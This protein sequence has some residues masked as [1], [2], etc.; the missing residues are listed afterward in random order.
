VGEAI[1]QL[2]RRLTHVVDFNGSQ[3][4]IIQSGVLIPHRELE[5]VVVAD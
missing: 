1:G 5:D 4:N 2:L 3:K